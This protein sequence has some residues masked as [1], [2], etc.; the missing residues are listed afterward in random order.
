MI[1]P[2]LG[3]AWQQWQ[4]SIQQDRVPH[5]VLITGAMG[6]GQSALAAQIARQAI[7]ESHDAQSDHACRQCHLVRA[8]NH[9]DLWVVEPEAEGKA[10]KVD[11]IR[12]VIDAVSQTPQLASSQC[13]IIQP[14]EAMNEK[15]ANALL[16]TLEEPPGSVLF[17]LVSHQVASLPV[18]IQSRCQRL[19][20]SV[21]CADTAKAWLHASGVTASLDVYWRLSLGAPLLAKL[22]AEREE[23]SLRDTLLTTLHASTQGCIDLKAAEQLKGYE[24]S[25]VLWHWRLILDDCQ[26]LQCQVETS[27]LANQDQLARLQAIADTMTP[28][29]FQSALVQLATLDRACHQHIS[30]NWQL[31]YESMFVASVQT[32][33]PIRSFY[34]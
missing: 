14:A 11:A 12:A 21:A 22:M 10:I 20:C 27:H 1:Y 32:T 30:L 13:V 29:S 31:A 16:K 34:D 17:C 7:C 24:P 15:A 26:R 23:L 18:T 19:S 33:Q 5:A 8:G 2:W 25:R 6:L 4:Q 28:A 9:P 3:P